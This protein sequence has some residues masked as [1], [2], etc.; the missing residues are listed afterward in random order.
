V[1][2]KVMIANR[3]EIAVR[4]ARSCRALGAG[5]VSVYSDPDRSALHVQMADESVHLPGTAPADTYLNVTALLEAARRTGAEAIHPGYGFL[6]EDAGFARAVTD[7]GLAW[8]G[9]SPDALA[10]A[11]NKLAARRTAEQA[12]V[13]LVPGLTEPVESPPTILDFAAEYGYP[14]AVKAAAGGG[15]RGLKVARSDGEVSA[16]FDS[17]RREAKAYFGSDQVYAERYLD[18]PKHMEVQLLALDPSQALWLGV[19]DCSL[20]RRHQKLIEE[21]PPPLFS[22]LADDMGSAA[23]A[24]SKACGYVNAG[25]AEFLVEDGDFFFL[26][27]NARLQVE[28]CV[29]EEVFGI[30]LVACQLAIACGDDTGLTQEGLSPSGHAIECRIIAEDPS[31]DFAPTPGRITTYAE[32]SGDGVRVDTGYRSGD[33]VPAEYDSLIAKL[34]VSASDR[35]G[36]IKGMRSAL[37]TFDIRG[38]ATSIPAHLA[39]LE[40]PSFVRGDHSTRTL[41][42]DDILASLRPSREATDVLMVGSE[43]VRLWH[44]AMA[45]FAAASASGV[46]GAVAA[47]MQGTILRVLVEPGARVNAGDPL[48]VLEAMKME[49]TIAAPT[50]GTVSEVGVSQGE[51]VRS[52]QPLVTIDPE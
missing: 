2:D 20:Q 8:V 29:T 25:T 48:A 5:V 1:F 18:D 4:I 36:A 30:D 11:G 51:T 27:L 14:V 6:A 39:L 26:E 44:P 28:H 13:P 38:I 9:P 43:P 41:E 34:I 7:A 31:H 16:A 49:S 3:G 33:H 37:E 21:T 47:P 23:V 45:A 12:G 32:P 22:E 52:G 40:D 15:G 42:R 50:T 17:A 35:V 19:R 10:L 24:F 46:G